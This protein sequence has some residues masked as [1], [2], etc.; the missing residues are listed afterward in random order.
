MKKQLLMILCNY[1]ISKIS[2]LGEDQ[3]KA[4]WMDRL[5]TCKIPISDTILLNSLNLPDNPSKATE[6]DPVLTAAM[7]EKLKKAGEAPSE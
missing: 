7:M 1:D 6:K 5:V 2:K 4:F 3:F